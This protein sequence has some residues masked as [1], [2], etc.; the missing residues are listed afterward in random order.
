VKIDLYL[1]NKYF[2]YTKFVSTP[3]L[4][5]MQVWTESLGHTIRVKVCG[6]SDVNIQ[7]DADIVAFSVYTF[8]APSAYR[9]SD[10][11][12][13]KGKFVILGGPHF[14]GH[15]TIEE[16]KPHCDVVVET[17]CMEQWENLLREIECEQILPGSPKAI[18]I[19]DTDNKFRFP[20]NMYEIYKTLDRYRFP[21]IMSSLGCP[22]HCE[23][24]N[25]YMSGKYILRDIPTIYKELS[26]MRGNVAVFCDA[27]FG[28]NKKYA[29]DLM[30]AIAPLGKRLF[31]Q[32]TLGILDDEKLMDAFARG[33][34]G[35]VSVGVESFAIP[36]KKHGRNTC[37]KNMDTLN[38]IIDAINNRGISMQ[39]NFICGMD[40]DTIDSFEPIYDFYRKSNL[41]EINVD[42]MAP[43]PNT[44][45]FDNLEREGRIFD[46]NWEH[47]DFHNVVYTPK[48]MTVDQLIE[49]Y[50]QLNRAITSSSMIV[51][52][53]LQILKT[54][55]ITLGW[56][57]MTWKVLYRLHA[58][59]KNRSLK[60]CQEQIHDAQVDLLSEGVFIATE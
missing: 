54:T 38:R 47:Y 9:L 51:R 14:H 58:R 5:V 41:N 13:Q 16:A 24:C 30:N 43:L 2:K 40:S 33:G 42:I 39:A 1:L 49:G 44:K 18:H 59:E 60:K 11:L 27:T 52:K 3:I 25:A 53:N 10:L 23:F 8:M 29:I 46:Y 35:W 55:G 45:V 4:N 7:T 19:V 28:L 20:D 6:E 34:V 50:I 15:K 12:R 17:I 31:I 21:L 57:M 48:N 32:T 56:P 37:D 26:A 22:Y 36:Q